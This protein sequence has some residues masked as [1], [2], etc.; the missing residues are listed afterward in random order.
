MTDGAT[1]VAPS[2]ARP[3]AIAGAAHA[4]S[5]P[6]PAGGDNSDRL[7]R[8]L[9][10]VTTV[11]AVST[12]GRWKIRLPGTRR[13]AQVE[14]STEWLSMSLPLRALNR[15]LD[16]DLIGGMLNRNARIEA[17]PH[18]IGPGLER[19]R[20]IVIDVAIDLLPWDS[21]AALETFTAG[22]IASLSAAV[23]AIGRPSATPP[24]AEL[25]RDELVGAFD[26]AG[27]PVQSSK[28]ERLEVPLEVPG[29]Y[30]AAQV[31][32]DNSVTHLAVPLLVNEFASAPLDCRNSV[33]VLLWLVAGRVRMVK[34]K[35]ARGALVL[36]VALLPGHAGAAAFAHACAA[37]SAALQQFTT[38]AE[39]LAT[40]ERLAQIYLANLGFSTT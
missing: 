9:R 22:V 31:S 8:V 36:E 17:S 37:L 27:W 4:V 39:L 16:P 32:Q 3:V 14:L 23:D 7:G 25:P 28:A 21:D 15:S 12:C 6:P 18:I 10:R 1:V 19:Q 40:D 2:S 24:P 13:T 20:Q 38:E 30:L 5:V 26:E 34:A 11:L 29:T 35:R 33:L